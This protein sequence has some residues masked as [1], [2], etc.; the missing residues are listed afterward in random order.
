MEIYE[1]QPR[2]GRA[3]FYGKAKVKVNKD[4]SE[5]LLSYDTPIIKRNVNGELMRLY[6]CDSD[7]INGVSCTTCSHLISFCG[8][9]K[10]DFLKLPY[11]KYVKK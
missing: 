8:L 2:N 11:R 4:G 7:F 1:L 5:V 3:S 6:R 9:H 10:K